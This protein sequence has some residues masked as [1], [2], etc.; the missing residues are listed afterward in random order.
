[1][2]CWRC[3]NAFDLRKSS[4]S[5]IER[6]SGVK[7]EPVSAPQPAD[8][9][10]SVGVEATESITQVSDKVIPA[11][12]STAEEFLNTSD[13]SAV[14]LLAMALVKAFGYT[15]MKSRSFLTTLENLVTVF[16]EARKPIYIPSF[17]YGVLRRFL[18]KEKVGSIQGL[19]FT[20][21]GNG[22][23]FDVATESS[24]MQLDRGG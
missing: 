12:K 9:A 15:E 6:E 11:F 19:A 13:L 17:A 4:I 24:W 16:L 22:A 1:M 21:D 14:E 20:T 2:Q 7:F 3:C 23:V 18:P 5:K 8:I 10:K